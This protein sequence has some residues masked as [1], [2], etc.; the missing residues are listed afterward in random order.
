MVDL[1]ECYSILV[2]EC[3]HIQE[4][5]AEKITIPKWRLIF[6]S[7]HVVRNN[8]FR[9][10][11]FRQSAGWDRRKMHSSLPPRTAGRKIIIQEKLL[12]ERSAVFRN[13]CA[14]SSPSFFTFTLRAGWGCG[15]TH[16]VTRIFLLDSSPSLELTE[17]RQWFIT[18]TAVFFQASTIFSHRPAQV[19]QARTLQAFSQGVPGAR[20]ELQTCL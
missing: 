4:R 14:V 16:E 9:G 2:H 12:H 7:T 8:R 19:R 15:A 6:A 3:I 17:M 20:T 18:V 13:S 5:H 1:N 11:S 10:S